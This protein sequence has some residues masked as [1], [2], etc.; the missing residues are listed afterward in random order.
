MMGRGC[1]HIRTRVAPI[2]PHKP[3]IKK[4]PT[5]D[6]QIFVV[7]VYSTLASPAQE[8]E[9]TVIEVPELLES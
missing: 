8:G 7:G 5:V 9:Q 1:A 4:D 2:I 6:A 3:I